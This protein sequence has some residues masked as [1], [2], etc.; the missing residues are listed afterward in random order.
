MQAPHRA[1]PTSR[2]AVIGLLRSA[3]SSVIT[4]WKAPIPAAICP[5][6]WSAALIRK[7]GQRSARGLPDLGE[8]PGSGRPKGPR[9][10]ESGSKGTG[11]M[12]GRG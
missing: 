9:W 6:V 2:S 8:T 4:S 1:V 3:V 7:S 11:P 5:N 10:V 12:C